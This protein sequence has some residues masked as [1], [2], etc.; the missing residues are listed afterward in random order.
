METKNQATHV[1]VIDG[2]VTVARGFRA[3]GV[4]CGIKEQ[5]KDL[6]LI[7]CD[8]LAS[9]AG[10]FT[11]NAVRAAPVLVSQERIQSGAARA[12]IVNSGNANACTGAEGLRDALEMTALTA[13]ALGVAE[14]FVLVAS[15][16]VIGI[17]LTMDAVRSGIPKA[18]SALSTESGPA[19]EAIL[20]TDAFAKT[21]GV[22]V[23]IG[24]T[25]VTIGGMAKGAGMI[26][27]QMATTLS[28][29]TTDAVMPAPLLRKVLRHAVNYS[30]NCISVDGDT[31]TN[32]SIFLLA[33]GLAGHPPITEEGEEFDRFQTALTEVTTALA[34]MVVRDGEGATKVVAVTV[35]GAPS[36]RDAKL[37]AQAVMTS[38]L[39]KTMLFGEEPNWG[40]M[41]AAVGRSGAAVVE[42][43]VAV[44]IAGVQ[45]VRRGVGISPN[46]SEAAEAMRAPE[47]E[48]VIDLQ[49]GSAGFTGWTSDLNDA[50]V[51]INAGYMT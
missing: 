36:T 44:W 51:K 25:A 28:F 1:A 29:V 20:T 42:D 18:V 3:A 23:E 48:I 41:L 8:T 21:A 17:P 43:R 24:G 50:Y 31:S 49:Q 32:D 37:A 13:Q 5:K 30:F 34:K 40:R 33:S 47:F 39:V 12:I 6:A 46:L 35:Q 14:E 22:E 11:T 45:V 19:A 26:H 16:G 15:T 9:A 27:P 2:G 4:H 10:M 7:V 38:P